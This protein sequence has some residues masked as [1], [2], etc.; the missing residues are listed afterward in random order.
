MG[1][2]LLLLACGEDSRRDLPLLLVAVFTSTTRYNDGL[3][4]YFII[5]IIILVL[6][7]RNIP[8][9]CILEPSWSF[10]SFSYFCYLLLLFTLTI[11][12][13]YKRTTTIPPII[14]SSLSLDDIRYSFRLV[15]LF[16]GFPLLLDT[17]NRTNKILNLTPKDTESCARIVIIVKYI[18]VCG[19][20]HFCAFHPTAIN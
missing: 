7:G 3:A 12:P 4:I 18:C 13:P 19:N 8:S 20:R 5:I 10:L 14:L 1:I 11:Y 9:H 6:Y 15:W 17:Q 16:A 2:P